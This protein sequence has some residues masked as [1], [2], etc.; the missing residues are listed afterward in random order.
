MEIMAL[1]GDS[2]IR[3][4]PEWYTGNVWLKAVFNAPE[5]SGTRAQ[6]VSF[7]VGARSAW[8]SHPGGQIL[9]VLAGAGL[10]GL[11][12]GTRQKIAAGDTVW[13]PPGELHWH[14][15]GAETD[16]EQVEIVETEA[17]FVTTWMARVS[18][19]DYKAAET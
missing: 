11:K 19:E 3:A 10:I 7:D 12:N 14:G 4:N 2:A 6:R 15:A 1:G 5:K 9:H 18:E 17:G 13:I 8:H 16:L